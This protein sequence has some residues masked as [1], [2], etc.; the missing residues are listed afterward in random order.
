ML[1][2]S[3]SGS[4]GHL[5]GVHHAPV[6][7]R[8]TTASPVTAVALRE[9]RK[10]TRSA[11][12]SVVTRRRR[13]VVAPR[14]NRIDDS[15]V[16]YDECAVCSCADCTDSCAVCDCAD[17]TCPPAR[18]L[19]RG[20][21]PPP[22]EQRHLLRRLR[23]ASGLGTDCVGGAQTCCV[24]TRQYSVCHHRN[25]DAIGVVKS[26]SRDRKSCPCPNNTDPKPSR[27]WRGGSPS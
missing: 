24:L 5:R 1:L 8:H 4:R 25:G 22:T 3:S 11:T 26:R 18:P 19:C 2:T 13:L 20:S 12:S 23:I 9:Q 6:S 16:H 17:C 27:F 10:T 15:G 14:S 21:A 7:A